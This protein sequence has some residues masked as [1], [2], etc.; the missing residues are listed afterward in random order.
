[1][2]DLQNNLKQSMYIGKMVKFKS[3]IFTKTGAPIPK[4]SQKEIGK[5]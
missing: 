4:I 1:M 2:K 3:D 5:I